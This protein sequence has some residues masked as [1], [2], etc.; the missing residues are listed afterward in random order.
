MKP[1]TVTLVGRA[2]SLA[3]IAGEATWTIT[4]N[5][6]QRGLFDFNCVADSQQ[7]IDAFELMDE[8]SLIGV[9]AE[10]Q[11]ARYRKLDAP[12]LVQRL[13]ILGKP[14]REQEVAA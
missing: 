5:R 3:F 6:G 14:A 13:E 2:H 11:P 12:L 8:G 7:S 10:L 4:I 1:E 9:I